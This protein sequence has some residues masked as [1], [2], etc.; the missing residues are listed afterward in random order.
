MRTTTLPSIVLSICIIGAL[1][2]P[3]E[4]PAP[5]STLQ[6]LGGFASS[7]SG[8]SLNTGNAVFTST[9]GNGNGGTTVTA[10]GLNGCIAN[11]NGALVARTGGGFSAS[12]TSLRLSG[13]TLLAT[14]GNGSGG[15]N[16]ASIDLNSFLIFI[17]PSLMTPDKGEGQEKFGITVHKGPPGRKS[18]TPGPGEGGPRLWRKK[19]FAHS[20]NPFG[21]MHVVNKFLSVLLPSLQNEQQEE[22]S[23]DDDADSDRGAQDFDELSGAVIEEIEMHLDSQVMDEPVTLEQTEPGVIVADPVNSQHYPE[24][25]P[26]SELD[27]PLTR[28]RK[29]QLAVHR[30]ECEGCGQ[31]VA[32][33]DRIDRSKVVQCAHTGCETSWVSLSSSYACTEELAM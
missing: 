27:A 7:C 21:T 5:R 16:P 31:E 19:I 30:Y 18:R 33:S 29:R 32:E 25:P 17:G 10:I 24:T 15:T 20:G 13:T 23:E 3:A 22:G 2:A 14:C 4:E 8:N 11:A 9:C 6:V 28:T 12:C 1:A 26:K